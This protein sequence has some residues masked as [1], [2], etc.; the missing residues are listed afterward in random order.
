MFPY[1]CYAKSVA[2][3][4]IEAWQGSFGVPATYNVQLK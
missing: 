4:G 2:I 1:C 3:A